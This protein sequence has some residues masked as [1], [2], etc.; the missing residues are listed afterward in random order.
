MT[1]NTISGCIFKNE[2]NPKVL[3]NEK[4]IFKART[5]GQNQPKWILQ[6]G[7]QFKSPKEFF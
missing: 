7:S 4:L 3:F 5:N 2:H 1:V 6:N